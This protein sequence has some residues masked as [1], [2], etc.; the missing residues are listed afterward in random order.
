MFRLG[1][2]VSILATPV[3]AALLLNAQPQQDEKAKPP[4]AGKDT[5]VV[6]CLAKGEQPDTYQITAENKTYILVGK[7][8]DL[9]KQVGHQISVSGAISDDKLP[10]APADAV[11]FRVSAM[12]KVADTCQ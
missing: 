2:L 6:G 8:E 4:N 1:R 10:G 9:E 12:S 7:K 3:F 11:K 5:T